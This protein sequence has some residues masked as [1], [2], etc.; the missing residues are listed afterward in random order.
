LRRPVALIA[1]LCIAAWGVQALPTLRAPPSGGHSWRETDGL[2]VAR[3]YCLEHAPFAEPRVDN[4]GDGDGRTGMELPLL[5]WIAGRIGCVTGDYVTPWRSLSFAFSLLLCACLWLI[6]RQRFGGEAG[7]LAAMAFA[8]APIVVYFSR[9]TQPDATAAGLATL[10]MWLASR[11]TPV[12]FARA[13]ARRWRWRS[14]ARGTAT[15]P[16]WRTRAGC[17]T[18]A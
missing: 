8:T 6:G 7:P 17:T 9:T 14:P 2:I 13:T 15:R 5:P 12:A 1:A 18:S 3:N 4:R 11:S 16:R 10:A